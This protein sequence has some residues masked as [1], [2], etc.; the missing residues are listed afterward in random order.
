MDGMKMNKRID[1]HGWLILEEDSLKPIEIIEADPELDG[2]APYSNDS[3]ILQFYF[4]IDFSGIY[5]K[6][7]AIPEADS[8]D[9]PTIS[10]G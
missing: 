10:N 8:F 6:L 9:P 7:I 4:T 2:E 3:G 5:P 1:F